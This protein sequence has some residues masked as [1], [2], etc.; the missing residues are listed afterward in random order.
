M[1]NAHIVMPLVLR[2][3]DLLITEGSDV[4]WDS[5]TWNWASMS[6]F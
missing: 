3:R 1:K 6:V 4:V 2:K 5:P